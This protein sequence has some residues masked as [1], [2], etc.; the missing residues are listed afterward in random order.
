[1]VIDKV[2]TYCEQVS[3]DGIEVLVVPSGTRIAGVN[4]DFN[5]LMY[6]FN[7]EDL[8]GILSGGVARAS[9]GSLVWSAS[10][11]SMIDAGIIALYINGAIE[12]FD[13][14]DVI[15]AVQ[16]IIDFLLAHRVKGGANVQNHLL[17]SGPTV[18]F[19]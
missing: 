4:I 14:E 9:S 5:R 1:M 16:L 19:L 17:R 11:R 13:A 12:R 10:S 6:Q 3:G 15:A 18:F 2:T 8:V 7:I